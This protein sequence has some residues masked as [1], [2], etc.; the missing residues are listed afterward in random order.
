MLRTVPEC[1][2]PSRIWKIIPVSG[3]PAAQSHR[4]CTASF[5]ACALETKQT[6]DRDVRVV[7]SADYLAETQGNR[8]YPWRVLIIAHE[9]R[10]LLESEM[11]YK[12]AKPCELP[13]TDWIRPGKVAWD[14]WNALNIYGVDFKS[15]VNTATYKYYIDFA[16][17]NGLEYI[18]LDEGWYD[19]KDIMKVVPEIDMDELLAYGR[20]KNVGI[21]L[22]TTWKALEDKMTEAMDRFEK[23]GIKGIK[24]DFMQRDDQ[25]MV[26]FYYRTAR[27]AGRHKLLVDYHGAYKPTGWIRTLPNVVSSEG[28]KGLENLKWSRLPDPEHNLTLPFTRMVAGPM[29]YTPGAMINKDSASFNIDFG[30]P[31]SLGTRCQQLALYVVFESPLQMLADNPSNYEREPGCME[32]LRQVPSVWDETRVLQAAMGDYVA[33]AR[34]NGTTWYLAAMT[35]WTGRDLD[36]SLGFLG[37]G[38]FQMDVWQDGVNVDKY[39]ADF[40]RQQQSVTAASRVKIRLAGGGGWVAIIKTK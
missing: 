23:W 25:W 14:W 29:D 32:F 3:L 20:Q 15:G 12:L 11:V 22:W 39:A 13:D 33:L 36:I 28:V 19:L 16:S 26:N 18:I 35:D 8:S 24:V 7:R 27:L 34:R 5:A 37:Q 30:A 40:Q 6:S 17:K 1:S 21:I 2:L 9:D 38:N 10:Q 4:P 31:M